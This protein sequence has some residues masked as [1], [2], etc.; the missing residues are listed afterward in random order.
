M[1]VALVDMDGVVA[2]TY[3]RNWIINDIKNV[4]SDRKQQVWDKFHGMMIF[5]EPYNGIILDIAALP[6]DVLVVILTGRPEKY[7]VETRKQLERWGVRHDHL[8]MRKDGN[9]QSAVTMKKKVAMKMMEIGLDI[10][11]AYDDRA[12]ICDMY[13]GLDIST[14]EVKYYG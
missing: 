12:D 14:V 5:D 4:P 8:I 2:D 7:E 10:V 9:K 6:A 1:K 3:H 13:R 11:K